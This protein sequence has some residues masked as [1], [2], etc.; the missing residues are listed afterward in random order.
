MAA[1]C[2]TQIRERAGGQTVDSAAVCG[3]RMRQ[4]PEGMHG[5]EARSDMSV[6]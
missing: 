5:D 1:M 6:N 3:D 4:G 2:G